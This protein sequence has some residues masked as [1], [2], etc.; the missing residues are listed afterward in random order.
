MDQL[1]D[2]EISRSEIVNDLAKKLSNPDFVRSEALAKENINPNPIVNLEIWSDLSLSGGFPGIMLM[3]SA[4]EAA[5]PNVG[6]EKVVHQYALTI[7]STLKKGLPKHHSL[8]GGLAGVCYALDSASCGGVRYKN[9]LEKLHPFLIHGV[10]GTY[11]SILEKNLDAQIPSSPFLFDIV[12]GVCGPLIYFLTCNKGKEFSPICTRIVTAL[13]RLTHEIEVLGYQVPGWYTLQEDQFLNEEK[14]KFSKGNFN[15]GVAHGIPGVLATL[16][17]AWEYGI[18][19]DGQEKAIEKIGDWLI[20]QSSDVE[21]QIFWGDRISFEEYVGEIPKHP[22]TTRAA[23]CYG[24]PGVARILFQAGSKL[25]NHVWQEIGLKAYKDIFNLDREKW[26]I[27]S[28]TLCHGVA[29]LYLITHLMGQDSG[30]AELQNQAKQ[31]KRNLLEYYSS[32]FPFGFQDLQPRLSGSLWSSNTPGLLE[33]SAGVGL[34][35]IH[36]QLEK[37]TWQHAFL[38]G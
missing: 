32:D 33:G 4:I 16:V 7:G 6:W 2:T 17:Y 9:I 28:P 12:L 26:H 5:Y 13:I 24:T 36:D 30:D 25:K 3:F 1:S 29:G 10:E 23:W 20:D 15:L 37:P 22:H 34:A 18:R 21:G 27:P 11:L 38:L 31:L 35:L 19:I 14:V 8:F